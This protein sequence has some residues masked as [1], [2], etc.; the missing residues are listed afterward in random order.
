MDTIY[1]KPSEEM[2]KQLEALMPGRVETGEA[3]NE[4]YTH[5][6]MA[7]YGRSMPD[8]VV[9]PVSTEEVSQIC[10]LCYENDV[11]FI[12]RGAGTGLVGGCVASAGGILIVTDKMN[13]IL[14]FDTENFIIRVQPG[15]YIQDIADAC[16]ERGLFY[17]PE[18]GE[19]Y[20]TVGG[21]VST[22]AGGMRAVKYGITRDY[23]KAMTV[24][25]PDGKVMRFGA[26]VN[27]TCS[28]Y[29]M[30]NL[31]CG[32]EGTLGIITELSMKIVPA[33]EKEASLLAAFGDLETC[34]A[35]VP[36]IMMA[37]LDPQAVEL[38]PR[39]SVAAIEEFLETKVYPEK[40]DGETAE[41]YLLVTLEGRN[42]D[43]LM[44]TLEEAAE[45]F[46]ENGALDVMVCDTA[47]AM[48]RVW[49]VRKAAL[50]EIKAHYE[51]TEECDVVVPIPQI[52]NFCNY[53]MSL[54]E[55][56][57]VT[58]RPSGHAGDG[59]MHVNCCANGM[60]EEEFKKVA[61]RFLEL[62]Y[63]KGKELGGQIS[64]EHGIGGAKVEYLKEWIG[65]EQVELMYAVKK[66]LDP[67]LL[68]NP[69]KV[70][71]SL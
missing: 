56:L 69:G 10:M 44:D 15:V 58:I 65:E 52:A 26:E 21:N 27:K 38:L 70:C 57:G 7:F 16:R 11:P 64:G 62:A 67:K 3:V 59:N 60:S 71:F 55:E 24:V 46:L 42:E 23:V 53:M 12:P 17:P 5:D 20:A 2:L 37:H 48:Q 18:P 45:V 36:Q 33:P 22:N 39:R 68:L 66:A 29:S 54:E 41:A 47:A 40:A 14:G 49:S 35:C 8:A 25:M 30:I 28:G 32:A 63:A 51:L 6:E 61:D 4:D 50:E 31:L 9:H 13:Q 19:M 43:L 1:K 34:V